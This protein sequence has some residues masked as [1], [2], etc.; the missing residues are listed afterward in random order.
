[1]DVNKESDKNVHVYVL[2]TLLDKLRWAFQGD[3]CTYAIGVQRYTIIPV[4]RNSLQIN[5]VSQYT[6][7]LLAVPVHKPSLCVIKPVSSKI[8]YWLW[9]CPKLRLF[10]KPEA[11]KQEEEKKQWYN[12]WHEFTQASTVFNSISPSFKHLKMLILYYRH[13]CEP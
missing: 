5:I 10:S 11:V 8:H 9:N 6:D 3:F 4:N 1:M 13:Q 2:L 12:S 7:T